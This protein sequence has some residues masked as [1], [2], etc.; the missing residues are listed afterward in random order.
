MKLRFNLSLTLAGLLLLGL[1][2]HA[3]QIKT[4]TQAGGEGCTVKEVQDLR[5]QV[6]QLKIENANLKFSVLQGQ[7][8][9]IISEKQKAI[10]ELVSAHPGMEWNDQQGKLVPIPPPP[11]AKPAPAAPAA[12]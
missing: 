4:P 9:P 7:A 12:K 11:P 8:T 3:Q 1:A 5:D 2:A 10:Q 6:A